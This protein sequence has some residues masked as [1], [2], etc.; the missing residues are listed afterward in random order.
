MHLSPIPGNSEDT[1][2]EYIR[3]VVFFYVLFRKFWCDT[4]CCVVLKAGLGKV[5]FDSPGIGLKCTGAQFFCTGPLYLLHNYKLERLLFPWK[6]IH[7]FFPMG[8]FI[9]MLARG[10]NLLPDNISF[11]THN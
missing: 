10:L 1:L 11:L 9:K 7:Y 5:S 3:H 8:L 2:C 4:R 6:P